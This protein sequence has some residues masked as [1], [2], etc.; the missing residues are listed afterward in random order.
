MMV[1]N[2]IHSFKEWRIEQTGLIGFVP[3]MGALHDGHF[4]LVKTCLKENDT[5]MVSIFVNPTQ[6][7][8]PEDL[9]NYPNTLADDLNALEDLGVQAVFLPNYNLLYP[10]DFRYKVSETE[11]STQLCGEHRLGHFDGVLTVLL[12]LFNIC[13]PHN[14]YFGEKDYQQVKLVEG[15]I[16]SLFLP[17]TLRT[18]ATVREDSGLAKSSRNKRL[19]KEQLQ[20]AS[21]LYKVIKESED[22]ASAKLKLEELGFK[23]DY[24]TDWGKRRLVAAWLG[25]VRLIDNVCI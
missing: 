20:K 13:I 1:F 14:V 16:E 2:D 21:M 3:T 5:V 25:D 17:I 6:F 8:N 4:E 19:S 23:V 24:I 10:D 15:M 18:V 12:K 22:C 7:D 9:K 11:L